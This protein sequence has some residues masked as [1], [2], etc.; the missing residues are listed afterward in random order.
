MNSNKTKY[1][2]PI[3]QHDIIH[4]KQRYDWDCGISC[5]LMVLNRSNR[6]NLLQHFHQICVEE[7]FDKR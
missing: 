3:V 2:P 6:Q 5:V 4:F 1:H 7:K